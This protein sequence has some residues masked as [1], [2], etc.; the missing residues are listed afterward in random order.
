MADPDSQASS[1]PVFDETEAL[2]R[3]GNDRELFRELAQMILADLPRALAEVESAL[4][5]QDAPRLHRLTHN[6]KGH[7]ATVGTGPLVKAG[8]ELDAAARAGDLEGAHQAHADLLRQLDRLRPILHEW[9][10]NN[11]D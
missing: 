9:L 7:L 11:G 6:L 8:R 2:A 4:A 5:Q 10:Q 1:G 3:T